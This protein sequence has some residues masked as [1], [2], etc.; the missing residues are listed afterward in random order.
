[1][2]RRIKSAPTPDTASIEDVWELVGELTPQQRHCREKGHRFDIP[3]DVDVDLFSNEWIEYT[4]CACHVLKIQRV[5]RDSGR[6]GKK[7]TDYSESPGYVMKGKGRIDKDGRGVFRIA[8]R[9]GNPMYR[10]ALA[11]AQRNQKRTRKAS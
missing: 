7:R 9:E 6:L 3:Y 4:K 8:N 2:P 1:M 5:H 10:K 11:K